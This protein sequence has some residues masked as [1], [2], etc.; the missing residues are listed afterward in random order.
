MTEDETKL[1]GYYDPIR[2][3]Q[4]KDCDHGPC[5]LVEIKSG[6][7]EIIQI[8]FY[9]DFLEVDKVSVLKKGHHY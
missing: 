6:A 9:G 7:G 1:G 3:E 8:G 4:S 5:L 2:V